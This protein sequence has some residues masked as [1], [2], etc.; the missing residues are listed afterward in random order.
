[1]GSIKNNTTQKVTSQP[2][3]MNGKTVRYIGKSGSLTK[4]ANFGYD[5]K[6]VLDFNGT[7]GKNVDMAGAYGM[8]R[9]RGYIQNQGGNNH[10]YQQDFDGSPLD[11]LYIR[12]QSATAGNW[13]RIFPSSFLNAGV[14]VTMRFV[15]GSVSAYG[16]HVSA[17]SRDRGLVECDVEFYRNSIGINAFKIVS[18][19]QYTSRNGIRQRYYREVVPGD[20]S[21]WSEHIFTTYNTIHTL[22]TYNYNTRNGYWARIF[23]RESGGFIEIGQQCDWSGARVEF[24]VFAITQYKLLQTKPLY[25]PSFKGT[26]LNSVHEWKFMS[27][28]TT[29]LTD[30]FS[31]E[32]GLTEINNGQVTTVGNNAFKNCISLENI[33]LENVES[34]GDDA[35]AQ[36]SK[37]TSIIFSNLRTI[38]GGAFY[39]SNKLKYIYIPNVTT[40]GDHA[41]GGFN[42]M[43][44]EGVEIWMNRKFNTESEKYR[45]FKSH[46]NRATFHW[47]NDDGSVYDP[48]ANSYTGIWSSPNKRG[49]F[50]AIT[51]VVHSR[52][53]EFERGITGISLPHA[54]TI[55][56]DAFRYCP[57]TYI[58]VPKATDIKYNV[59]EH[60][61]NAASTEVWINKKYRESDYRKNQI[62]GDYNWTNIT[63][64]WTNDD[65]TPA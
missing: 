17:T 26:F 62:F 6:V 24:G 34:I 21:T 52:Q 11:L 4:I 38:G 39:R 10:R 19:D 50:M 33:Y 37:L 59:F 47:L 55:W 65:G 27:S 43:D 41:F 35:F 53:F 49:D 1:M 13:Q 15:A 56:T 12:R 7:Y 54:E 31:W 5:P 45:I 32:L 28:H 61:V 48:N 22:C 58:R 64:H 14:K 23:L 60:V 57:L 63:F 20:S 46:M 2:F 44:G 40:I 42:T 25:T 3:K 29:S 51:D 9:K 8:F 18:K 36:A 30:E 16:S